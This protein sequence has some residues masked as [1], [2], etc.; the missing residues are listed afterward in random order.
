MDDF[1]WMC[2]ELIHGEVWMPK[3]ADGVYHEQ[4]LNLAMG[5][6]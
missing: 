3:D 2:D 6:K 4:C 5:W 1:C